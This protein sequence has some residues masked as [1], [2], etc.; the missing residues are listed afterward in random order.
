M[1]G[2]VISARASSERTALQLALLFTLTFLLFACD[3]GTGPALVRQVVVEPGAASM[4]VGDRVTYSARA[5]DEHGQDIEG[6]N[7]EWST[8]D[9]ALATVSADGV[10]TGLSAGT[11][12]VRAIIDGKTGA[13]SLLVLA[14]PV[15]T[16]E[17]QPAP[18][19]LVLGESRKLV[20]I[21]RDS[22]GRVLTG[23]T[24][25][26]ASSNP[27]VVSVDDGGRVTAAQYGSAEVSS[28]VEDRT[29]SVV[30]S[31]APAAV[32]TV[33]ISPSSFVIEIGEQKQLQVIARD[34]SGSEL[35]GRDV[36][37]SVDDGT[38]SVTQDG[39]VTGIRKGSVTVFASIEGVSGDVGGTIVN[40]PPYA[41][42]LVY[43]RLDPYGQS[44]LLVLDISN[45]SGP[46][47]INAD[48]VSRAPSP[49]PDGSRVAFAVSMDDLGTGTRVD[50][51][52]AVDRSG[53][54]LKRLTSDDGFDDW[55]AWSPVGGLIAYQH[56][57]P[58][59]RADIWM[60]KDDGSG[61]TN[62]TS[63]MMADGFRSTP[64][65]TR[66]G[67]RI[68]FSQ[69]VNDFSGTSSSI[70][71]MRADGSEKRQLTSTESAFDI[72]P[73]WSPD[74]SRV[75]FIRYYGQE[76]D[77]T[78]LDMNSGTTTRIPFPGIDANPSWSPD[79][80]LIAFTSGMAL[81]TM[82][83]D[84][85]NVRLRTADP[86]WGGGAGPAWINKY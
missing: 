70:W 82:H 36:L 19:N 33:A 75:A 12:S 5:L 61:H 52:Y 69:R 65:W 10:V 22:M 14:A 71:V 40:P 6:R 60:M 9:E 86:S 27:A 50:D 18:V 16:I 66:D 28:S 48:A 15:A 39:V 59:G 21:A 85:S 67:K 81:Y 49:S 38:V 57:E 64:A 46:T 30:V 34:L 2:T 74:G 29:V 31:V 78:I 32:A 43:Y 24:T 84:G 45:G 83:P 56:F 11:V 73:T 7:V 17:I 3:N 72:S 79:G 37:W 53:M 13:T 42:D 44:E 63:E 54:N 26:W 58:E 23:R 76:P 35:K 4:Q 20:A 25:T 41:F 80:K 51:I 1:S 8:T 55:P 47:R 77:I 62:L 68:A